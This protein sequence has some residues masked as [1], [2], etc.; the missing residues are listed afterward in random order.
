MGSPEKFRFGTL[1][2]QRKLAEDEDI[3]SELMPGRPDANEFVSME[4]IL[5]VVMHLSINT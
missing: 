2:D 3:V 1:S 4:D 5:S